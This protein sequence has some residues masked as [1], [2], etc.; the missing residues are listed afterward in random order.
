M[1]SEN[2]VLALSEGQGVAL[3]PVPA[4]ILKEQRQLR[5]YII[6][7][8]DSGAQVSMVG[9]SVAE[10]IGLT[11]RRTHIYLNKIGGVE[12]EHDSAI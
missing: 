8:F 6:V 10:S 1:Q 11:G 2:A 5:T 4:V 7:F 3:L 12:E 9:N